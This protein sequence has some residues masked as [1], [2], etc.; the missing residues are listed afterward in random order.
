MSPAAT[1]A[2][3]AG[4]SSRTSRHD[5]AAHLLRLIAFEVSDGDANLHVRP[6]QNWMCRC[7]SRPMPSSSASSSGRVSSSAVPAVSSAVPAVRRRPAARQHRRARADRR[8]NQ[9]RGDE[10]PRTHTLLL[11]SP[12]SH[13][14]GGS[15]AATGTSSRDVSCTAN[16]T[17]AARPRSVHSP[18]PGRSGVGHRLSLPRGSGC[19]LASSQLPHAHK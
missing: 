10:C 15:F 1:P 4:L 9:P 14:R 5:R 8:G 16:Q 12:G 19:R 18:R 17:P 13:D 3:E 2:F 11:Q 6:A 7:T